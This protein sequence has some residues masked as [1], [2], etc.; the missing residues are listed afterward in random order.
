METALKDATALQAKHVD[1]VDKINVKQRQ[2]RNCKS[3]ETAT[4]RKNSNTFEK[5][6]LGIRV[7]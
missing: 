7:K 4:Q 5:N 6:P 1:L 2:Y 3:S